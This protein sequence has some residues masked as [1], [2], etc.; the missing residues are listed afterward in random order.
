MFS[1]K[2]LF[3]AWLPRISVNSNK[4]YRPYKFQ[5]L[6]NISGKFPEIL[7]LWKIY[8]PNTCALIFENI[9][10]VLMMC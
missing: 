6:A 9:A 10:I 7:N 4:N 5:A 3:L 2:N 8:N 1:K